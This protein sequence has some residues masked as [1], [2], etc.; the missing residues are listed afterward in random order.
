MNPKSQLKK[1]KHRGEERVIRQQGNIIP[2]G[3]SKKCKLNQAGQARKKRKRSLRFRQK[4][5]QTCDGMAAEVAGL[6]IG[7]HMG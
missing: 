6:L 5:T 3:Q 7:E 1:K 2:D 4:I